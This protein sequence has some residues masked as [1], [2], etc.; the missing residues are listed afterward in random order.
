VLRR[1]QRGGLLCFLVVVALLS[2]P[3]PDAAHAAAGDAATRPGAT[4]AAHPVRGDMSFADWGHCTPDGVRLHVA[5]LA[6][7][8]ALL[9]ECGGDGFRAG[10]R[11][12]WRFADSRCW[13]H[14]L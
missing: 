3:L 10:V 14:W 6:I 1:R 8:M 7:N 5:R 12:G 9:T 2:W 4:E 13:T 11:E